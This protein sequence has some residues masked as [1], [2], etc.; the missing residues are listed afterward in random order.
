[1]FFLD[2]NKVFSIDFIGAMVRGIVS[3]LDLL[4]LLEVIEM[5]NWNLNAIF[6]NFWEFS[7]N[8]L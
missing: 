8:E 6:V 4:P 1:M 5:G 3:K 7:K 2:G